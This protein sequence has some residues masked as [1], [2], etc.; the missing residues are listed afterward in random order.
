[1]NK[2][3]NVL[4]I[5]DVVGEPGL[6][7][8]KEHLPLLIEKYSPDLVIVNGENACDGKSITEKEAEQIFVLGA[9]II[10]S[11]NHV[12]DNWKSKPLLASNQK[13]LRPYNYPPGNAGR[14]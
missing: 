10:T 9:D 5:G 11:G 12:W 8:L 2:N 1:M 14:G 7:A 6:S 13:V 3:L 4:F